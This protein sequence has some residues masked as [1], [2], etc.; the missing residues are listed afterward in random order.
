M[1]VST[2]YLRVPA[3]FLV[4]ISIEEPIGDVSGELKLPGYKRPKHRDFLCGAYIGLCWKASLRIKDA[5]QTPCRT[6]CNRDAVV[7]F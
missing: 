6:E 2:S 3:H 1:K 5:N 7:N 4:R